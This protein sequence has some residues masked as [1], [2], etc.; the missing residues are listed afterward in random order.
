MNW[1]PGH[2]EG[3]VI[4]RTCENMKRGEVGEQDCRWKGEAEAHGKLEVFEKFS[5]CFT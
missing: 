5:V 4:P 1:R 2:S 3:E